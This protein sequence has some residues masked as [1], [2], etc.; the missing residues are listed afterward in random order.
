MKK[1]DFNTVKMRD[2]MNSKRMDGIQK[3]KSVVDQ[4]G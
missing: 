3:R 1:E 2:E 4:R